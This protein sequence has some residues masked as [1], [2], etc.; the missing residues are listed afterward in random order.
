MKTIRTPHKYKMIFS[1]ID[2]TLLDSSHRVPEET[3]QK[4]LELER[5]GVPFVLVSAR[6][7]ECMTTIQAQIGN[8]APM[9]CYS[10]ALVRDEDGETLYSCRMDYDVAVEIKELLDRE[11]PEICCNTYGGSRWVVDDDRNPWVMKEEAITGFK[12]MAGNMEEVFAK[13]RMIHKFLLMGDEEAIER[14]EKHLK[15]DYPQLSI[16]T[17]SPVYMEVMDGKVKKSE[18]VRFLCGHC[19]AGLDEV[20]AFGDGCND[21]DMLQAVKNSYA[22]ANAPSVVRESAAHVTLDNDHQGLLAALKE[23]FG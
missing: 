12:A 21:M 20:L 16:A 2:G 22:M 17:S 19:G 13:D 14:L 9:V 10:G 1:D 18:G 15:K 6:M 7:P 11:Y 8:R 23:N 4:I 5:E 3:R